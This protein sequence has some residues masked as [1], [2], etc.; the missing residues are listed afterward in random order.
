MKIIF[1]RTREELIEYN[2]Y[3][4]LAKNN[5][6]SFIK[7]VILRARITAQIN[8]Y[9][10]D[11]NNKYELG[12]IMWDLQDEVLVVNKHD[13]VIKVPYSE[14]YC[15]DLTDKFIFVGVKKGMDSFIPNTAFE[16][17]KQKEEF[18]N[19]LKNKIVLL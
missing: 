14:I 1:K 7:E 15:I 18:V 5:K 12:E 8:N 2:L 11:N 16:S 4:L 10:S 17:Q 9:L 13:K 6:L 3:Q 19:F